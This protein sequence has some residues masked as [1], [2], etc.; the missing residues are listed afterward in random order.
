MNRS[1]VT[2][3]RK[4]QLLNEKDKEI[5]R[6]REVGNEIDDY[7]CG[8]L[9]DYGGGDVARWQDY[10]RC[11]IAACNDHWKQ[12]IKRGGEWGDPEY[13]VL[14]IDKLEE[15]VIKKDKE[16]EMRNG[17][18]NRQKTALENQRKE[19]ERLIEIIKNRERQIFDL[20]IKIFPRDAWVDAEQALMRIYEEGTSP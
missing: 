16:P 8:I 1:F 5:E 13:A 2:W 20:Y 7:D 14:R 18:M 15:G 9:N 12:A 6:L 19:T 10:I 4:N 3:Q 17:I 11:E